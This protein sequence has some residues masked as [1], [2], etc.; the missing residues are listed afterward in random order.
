MGRSRRCWAAPHC[1]RSTPGL[2]PGYLRGKVRRI[3]PRSCAIAV[4]SLLAALGRGMGLGVLVASGGTG[5]AVPL[6]DG[7]GRVVVL[8]WVAA[9]SVMA[10]PFTGWAGAAYHRPLLGGP[11]RGE[12]HGCGNGH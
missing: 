4:R 5:G 7:R 8:G 3:I 2:R 1:G 10:F 11:G 6:R 9:G 12:E